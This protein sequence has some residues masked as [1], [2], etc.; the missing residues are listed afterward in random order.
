MVGCDYSHFF[1]V[2][3]T[4][5][6]AVKCL[7]HGSWTERLKTGFL[8]INSM[9]L[10]KI[11]IGRIHLQKVEEII[12]EKIGSLDVSCEQMYSVASTVALERLLLGA[13]SI[14]DAN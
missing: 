13:C 5:K 3:W 14:F 9:S 10:Q 2:R 12:N 7:S 6:T 1:A 8:H 11:Q 4:H